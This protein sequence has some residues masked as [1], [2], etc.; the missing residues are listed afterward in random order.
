MANPNIVNVSSIKGKTDTFSLDVAE[1]T[2]L[3]ASA[4]TIYKINVIQVA[5][6][7]GV[8][9][10]DV[11]IKY[12]DG[13]NDRAIAST[14][15]VPADAAVVITDKNT[16]FYLEENE[17]IKGSASASADLTCLISYEVIE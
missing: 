16:G 1:A 13:A 5:N 9:A 12:G 8:N 14:L 4:N 15:S 3:T 10:A 11:T 6:I 2:L 17:T 7:D